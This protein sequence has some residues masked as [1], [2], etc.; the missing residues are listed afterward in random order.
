MLVGFILLKVF[1]KTDSAEFV[2]IDVNF[3]DVVKFNA[4]VN[5]N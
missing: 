1:P 2:S 4:P 5:F 3:N